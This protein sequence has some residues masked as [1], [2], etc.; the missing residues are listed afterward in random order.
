MHLYCTY[1]PCAML[2]PW[3]KKTR[4]KAAGFQVSRR[5]A[6]HG[7]VSPSLP[8]ESCLYPPPD[9][10]CSLGRG[11]SFYGKTWQK[12]NSFHEPKSEPTKGPSIFWNQMMLCISFVSGS[13]HDSPLSCSQGANISEWQKKSPWKPW[14]FK[15]WDD[16]LHHVNVKSIYIQTIQ[17]IYN[18]YIYLS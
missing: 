5:S 14:S 16:L 15:S 8:W 3:P 11:N 18:L 4:E 13:N 6:S 12:K 1:R 9:K 17:D 2:Q 7:G 10:T